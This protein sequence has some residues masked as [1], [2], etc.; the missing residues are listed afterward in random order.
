MPDVLACA[1]LRYLDGIGTRETR[2][3]V[4]YNGFDLNVNLMFPSMKYTQHSLLL[5]E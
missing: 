3:L 1:S 5:P 2:M 4:K